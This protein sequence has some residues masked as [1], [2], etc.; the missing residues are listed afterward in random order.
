MD[1]KFFLFLQGDTGGN[2]KDGAHVRGLGY[3]FVDGTIIA[4]NDEDGLHSRDNL[5]TSIT[6]DSLIF[7]NGAQDVRID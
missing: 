2:G 1:R 4:N 5:Y 3:L 7:N 6:D